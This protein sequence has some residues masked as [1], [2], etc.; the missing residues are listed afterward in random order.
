MDI[1]Y[2]YLPWISDTFKEN[3][4]NKGQNYIFQYNYTSRFIFRCGYTYVYNS[5]GNKDTY[6]NNNDNSYSIRAGFESA[7][8]LL[9]LLSKAASFPKNSNGQ[10]SIF[11]IPYAQYLKGD[12]D[13]VR[14]LVLDHR[15]TL[16]IHAFRLLHETYH[17]RKFLLFQTVESAFHES[18]YAIAFRYVCQANAFFLR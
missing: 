11:S 13:Y 17:S 10:Y 4:I 5:L 3:Y 8:N 18:N 15:N 12:F 2:I 6:Y 14:K 7:G 16:A 9:Y 1:S